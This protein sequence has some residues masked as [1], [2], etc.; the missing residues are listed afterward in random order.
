MS[1]I[2]GKVYRIRKIAAGARGEEYI[3]AISTPAG[4][5]RQV[6]LTGSGVQSYF[7]Y[8]KQA[9]REFREVTIQLAPTDQIP[10]IVGVTLG[11]FLFR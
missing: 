6:L 11:K 9:Q 2:Q 3:A 1:E 8:L 5:T 4:T 7:I 10:K